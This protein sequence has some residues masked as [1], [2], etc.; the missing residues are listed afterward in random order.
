M[1]RIERLAAKLDEP[2]L[3]TG[4][5]NVQYLTGFESSNTALLVDPALALRDE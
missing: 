5:V 3:V 2:L 1:N 4:L